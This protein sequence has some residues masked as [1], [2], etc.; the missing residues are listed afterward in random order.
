M[1]T[2]ISVV[3]R[4]VLQLF[5][6]H[7]RAVL[8]LAGIPLLYT[9][10]FGSLFIRNTLTDVP[11]AICN[12]D[13]CLASRQLVQALRD[14]PE[15]SIYHADGSLDTGEELLQQ[16]IVYGLVIIPHDYGE[17][18][19]T[20]NAATV[21]L[22]MNNAN[23]V[24]GGTISRAL[25]SVAGEQSAALVVQNRLAA[26]W[27][28]VQAEN[29]QLSVSNRVL[30]NPTGGYID[31]FL[32]ALIVH[33]SQI[34]Q[35]FVLGPSLVLEKKRRRSELQSYPVQFLAAKLLVYSLLGTV[36]LAICM[37]VGMFFFG[38]VC[39]SSGGELLLLL[40]AYVTCMTAFAL[41]LGSWIKVPYRTIT[42]PLFYIMPS[43]LFSGAIWPRS[44]MDAMSLL[45]SYLMPIGYVA[46]DVRSLLVKG[47]AY[48]WEWHALILFVG[49]ALFFVFAIK[50][51]KSSLGRSAGA[52]A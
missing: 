13:G 32:A 17:K 16:G 20:G 50:G 27:Q 28:Q 47:V 30:Y 9:L 43:V 39:R 3:E 40:S 38:M 8:L 46:N 1:K 33:A 25:A 2:F 48:G 18:L 44:S 23:T 24:I 11:L 6:E 34:A 35:V 21:E 12:Q 26:G 31:F 15:I 51:L 14:T 41:F 7:K 45:L 52:H 42:Y 22:V 37:T 49:A 19:A 5:L 36:V 4:E 10:L 29:V